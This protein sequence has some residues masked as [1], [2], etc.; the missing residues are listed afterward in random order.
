MLPFNTTHYTLE[1]HRYLDK[2]VIYPDYQPNLTLLFSVES[3]A[4]EAALDVS[5]SDLRDSIRSLHHAS[6]AL[7]KKKEKA[8]DKLKRI[9]DEW[10]KKEPADFTQRAGHRVME[11]RER[12][13]RRLLIAKRR[14]RETHRG[15]VRRVRLVKRRARE[16]RGKTECYIHSLLSSQSECITLTIDTPAAEKVDVASESLVDSA[17]YEAYMIAIHS[18]FEGCY[19]AWSRVGESGGGKRRPK[20]PFKKVKKAVKKIQAVNKKL[21]A[22]ERGFI[23]KDGIKDREWFKH[24]GVAPGKWLGM[25]SFI[26]VGE[27]HRF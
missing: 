8:E 22:F 13:E 7:D 9:I 6:L 11:L 21:I 24:L 1:L 12:F 20:F 16:I 5:F 23:S 15:I 18:G 3:L 27:V 25:Y 19:G 17:D 14:A 2:Y 10:K 4:K 26:F